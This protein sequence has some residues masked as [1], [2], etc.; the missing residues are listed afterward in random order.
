MWSQLCQQELKLCQRHPEI[1]TKAAV[2]QLHLLDQT[3]KVPL[4]SLLLRSG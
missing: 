2:I 4:L 1:C 3:I